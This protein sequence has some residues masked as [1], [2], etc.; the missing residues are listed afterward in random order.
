MRTIQSQ[1]Y[2]P[3]IKMATRAKAKHLALKDRVQPTSLLTPSKPI[4][5]VD[6]DVSTTY[7]LKLSSGWPPVSILSGKAKEQAAYCYAVQV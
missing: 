6:V 1:L 3:K 4:G 2:G 7:Q 5:Q